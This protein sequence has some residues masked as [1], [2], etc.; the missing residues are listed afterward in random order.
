MVLRKTN[1]D[2]SRPFRLPYAGFVALIAFYICNLMI[3]WTGWITVSKMMIAVI[4][5]LMFF[6]I[7]CLRHKKSLWVQQWRASWWLAPYLSGMSLLSFLGTFGGGLGKL[8]F[9]W[10][11]VLIGLLTCL[12]YQVA[13]KYIKTKTLPEPSLLDTD[14]I[15][16]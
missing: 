8:A 15:S 16:P 4:I 3:F 2:Q 6:G 5:G 11:F 13:I 9:G 14:S 10:D 7:Y 12:T 1:P